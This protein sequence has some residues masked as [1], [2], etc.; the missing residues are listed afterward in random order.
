MTEQFEQLK[1]NTV[2][3]K[4]QL[5]GKGCVRFINRGRGG[6][7]VLFI[8]NSITLHGRLPEIGWDN[9]WGMAASSAE[10]DYLH[11]VMAMVEKLDENAECC[12]CQV[13]NWERDYRNGIA[14]LAEY[15]EGRNF[16]ADI[17]VCRFV[18]NAPFENFDEKAFE[19]AYRGLVDYLNLSGC[20]R[21]LATDG[22]WKHP[23][24]PVIERI[25]NE[26]VWPLV[27]ISDL[28]ELD[29]M[30]AIGLFEHEGV[31]RHPG[32]LGMKTIADRIW[33]RM[34]EWI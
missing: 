16:D 24:D 18:E 31:A 17:I 25:A 2:E 13:A 6:K 11:R 1:K 8:G 30:K 26:N 12:L 4:N 7:R 28:G 3:S 29:E 34:E 19:K 21:V 27:K 22:F 32:D 10:N 9:E 20:A 33:E 23:A 14:R 15:E 5:Q